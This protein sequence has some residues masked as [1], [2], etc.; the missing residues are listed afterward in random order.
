MGR[1]QTLN[2]YRQR[3]KLPL[4]CSLYALVTKRSAFDLLDVKAKIF[5]KMKVP[6]PTDSKQ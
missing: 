4:R 1:G 5:R 3:Y 6:T 2:Y